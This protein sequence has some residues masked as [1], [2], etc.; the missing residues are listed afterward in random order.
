[1]L[2]EALFA[3]KRQNLCAA[4]S[5]NPVEHFRGVTR[6]F[7]FFDCTVLQKWAQ[8]LYKFGVCVIIK[9]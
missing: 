6:P 9:S 2:S 1:M 4:K 5:R 8:Y 7:D 3:I